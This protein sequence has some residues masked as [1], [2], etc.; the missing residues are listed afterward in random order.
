MT[1]VKLDDQFFVHRKIIGLSKDAKLFFIAATAHSSASL[2]DGVL[3]PAVIRVVLAITDTD[4]VCVEELINAGLLERDGDSLIIHDYLEYNPSAA[5]VIAD[6]E[7]AKERAQKNRQNRKASQDERLENETRIYT[8]VHP[9]E[10]HTNNE[11]SPELQEEFEKSSGEVQVNESQTFEKSS[12]KVCEKFKHPV[13]VPGS[14]I[15][16]PDPEPE[17]IN[18]AAAENLGRPCVR[19][20]L[21]PPPLSACASSPEKIT[22]EE[23]ALVRQLT[24]GDDAHPALEAGDAHRLVAPGKPRKDGLISVEVVKAQWDY[25]PFRSPDTNPRAMFIRAIV[26]DWAPPPGWTEAQKAAEAKREEQRKRDQSRAQSEQKQSDKAESD[27]EFDAWWQQ[28]TFDQHVTAHAFAR[29][30]LSKNPALKASIQRCLNEAISP[31]EYKPL[32]GVYRST[33]KEAFPTEGAQE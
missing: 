26:G 17:A 2:L 13:P 14:R 6:R 16:D 24:A 28:L 32:A 1:W 5:N 27:A 29:D 9:N 15:P 7:A 30:K 8:E 4:K 22:G 25:W 11:H 12:K 3:P 20:E 21:P 18:T 33:L 19:E 31:L 10:Q 23:A